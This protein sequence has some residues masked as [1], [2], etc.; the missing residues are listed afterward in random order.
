MKNRF[1]ARWLR[2]MDRCASL[3]L[4]MNIPGDAQLKLA[5]ITSSQIHPE[6][7]HLEK[8]LHTT[9]NYHY[10]VDHCKDLDH[11]IHCG[12]FL[13]GRSPEGSSVGLHVN[14]RGR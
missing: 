8:E 6:Q 1:P 2:A 14:R 13:M 12:G 11:N 3:L 7:L 10:F 9:G 4:I 5:G